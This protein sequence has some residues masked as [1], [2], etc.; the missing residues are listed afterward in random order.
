MGCKDCCSNCLRCLFGYETPVKLVIN[1][2]SVGA[3]F[4]LIQFLVITYVA[5]YV[6]WIRRV[7]Q[8]TDSVV[9]SVS[10]KVKGNILTNSSVAGVHVWDV[11]EYVIPPQGE[12]SFFVLTNVILTPGQTQ[13]KCPEIPGKLTRC[14]S[15][16]DCKEGLNKVRSNGVQTGRCVQYSDTIKTCEVQAWCPLENDTIVPKPAILGAAED[17]TVLIKNNIQY[18]KF[19]FRKR[20]IL[21]HINSTYLKNCT[22]D[23][24]TDPHCPVFRLGDMVTE[25]GEN[26]SVMALKGGVIGIFINWNCDLDLPER[27]C[28]PKYTFSRLDN[29]N[30]E[31]N[32]APGYNFRFAKYYKN[33]E[34]IETRTLIKAFGIRFDVIV[35]GKAGKFNIVP[36]IVNIGA[37]LTLL[38][39]ANPI[40]DWF[41]LT[42]MKDRAYYAK[43]KFMH[44]NQNADSV[45][46]S[47]MDTS[48]YG[49]Q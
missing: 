8:D 14:D 39:L 46:L 24:K 2:K 23:R 11:S 5:V 40:C 47:S 1:N 38:N 45:P 43:H 7:Y 25:A 10:T 33:N 34:N 13:S 18:P 21:Q 19:N 30:P 32:V 20:N 26:F 27:F 48:P 9:S 31:N 29:K 49:T 44:L 42:F 16:S 37:T 6:C 41:M 36:T 3:L 28:V 22:F 35:F 12:N 17:F 4:R 15:D